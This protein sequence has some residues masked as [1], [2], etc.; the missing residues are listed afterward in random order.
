[1]K[2]M[3]LLFILILAIVGI[4]GCSSDNGTETENISTI[5]PSTTNF[6]ERIAEMMKR[7]PSD[8]E[9]FHAFDVP[10]VL[11][12]S[13]L[14]LYRDDIEIRL[15]NHL[16]DLG[17]GLDA[18]DAYARFYFME[19]EEPVTMLNV[20]TRCSTAEAILRESSTSDYYEGIE[21][22]P[23]DNIVTV[24][25]PHEGIFAF[26]D[27]FI[28]CGSAEGVQGCID[29]IQS[30]QNYFYH[31]V[32]AKDIIGRLPEGFWVELHQNI[33]DEYDG[34]TYLGAVHTKI[35]NQSLK[36]TVVYKFDGIESSSGA[37]PQIEKGWDEAE[38]PR[39]VEVFLDGVYVTVV[40]EEEIPD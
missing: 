14:G 19:L 23:F 15:R 1:M 36:H 5:A 35:D 26:I 7:A 37:L 39:N 29:A 34:F 31:N 24:L 8:A 13:S 40:I 16:D 21:V 18:V 27:G 38:W 3:P 2:K 10:T 17:L 28:F 20:G 32:N 11:E 25:W 12:D 30:E 9:M 6:S 33:E 4:I 22:W